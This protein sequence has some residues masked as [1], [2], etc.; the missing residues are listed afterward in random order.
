MQ[1]YED[2]LSLADGR[3]I[4]SSPAEGS[5]F[6]KNWLAWTLLL[7]S[8]KGLGA[9]HGKPGLNMNTVII[10]EREQRGHFTAGYLFSKE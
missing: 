9:A 3:L 5:G 2:S 4:H 7:R 6:H 8:E 1:G 10:S